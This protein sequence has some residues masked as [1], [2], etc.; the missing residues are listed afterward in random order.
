MPKRFS[1]LCAA[2]APLFAAGSAL[3]LPAFP[4]AEGF[5]A[6]ATGGRGGDVHHV[7]G[8]WSEDEV[9]SVAGP[10]N[11]AQDVTVEYSTMSEALTS[12]HQYGALIRMNE[13]AS[14][15]YNRN[16][17]SNNVSRNPRPGTYVGTQLD[18]EF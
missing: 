4:G 14:V 18:F 6:N 16:L 11:H 8:S 10:S 2:L 13:S 9:I 7:S 17:F 15:S 3:A 12:G 5:G 1:V